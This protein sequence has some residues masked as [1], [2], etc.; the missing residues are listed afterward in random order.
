MK[1]ELDANEPQRPDRRVWELPGNM[2][3][4]LG[5]NRDG[6]YVWELGGDRDG[7]GGCELP[8]G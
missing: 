3:P 4:E 2:A 5:G 7:N 1:G 8:A 6:N